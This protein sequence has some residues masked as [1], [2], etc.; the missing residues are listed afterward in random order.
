VVTEALEVWEALARFGL[1][2]TMSVPVTFICAGAG[3]GTVT[4]PDWV[5]VGRCELQF[6]HVE[7]DIDHENVP[8][9]PG[10][11]VKMI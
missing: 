7:A 2:E 1:P 3:V 10:V 4:V 9:P 8:P 6:V 5:T 11:N